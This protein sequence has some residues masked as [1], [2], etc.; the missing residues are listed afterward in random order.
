MF[1]LLLSLILVSIVVNTVECADFHVLQQK[2]ADSSYHSDYIF[3]P[4]IPFCPQIMNDTWINGYFSKVQKYMIF[5][6]P[7]GGGSSHIKSQK[8]KRIKHDLY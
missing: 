5:L 8:C 6:L 2:T 3:V 4:T 1:V 7:S